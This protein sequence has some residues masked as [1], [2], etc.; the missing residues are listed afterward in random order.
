MSWSLSV[1]NGDLSIGSSGL[2][3]VT[4][5]AKLTQDLACDILEPMG[6]DPL[7]PT[8]GSV[9]DGGTDANGNAIPGVIGDANDPSA[10]TFVGAEIQRICRAYQAQQIARNQADVATYGK[11]TLTADEALL[12]IQSIQITQAQDNMMVACNLQTGTGGLALNVPI[13]VS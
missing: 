4:G 11:S 12:A 5:G 3:V 13:T 1:T 6:N 2:N 8:F 9:I 7:H 10:A